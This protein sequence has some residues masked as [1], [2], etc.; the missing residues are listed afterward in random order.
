M[1]ATHRGRKRT[2]EIS[3][4]RSV[5]VCVCGARVVGQHAPHVDAAG[6]HAM[7]NVVHVL[8]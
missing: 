2:G 6:V 1:S 4:V 8:V 3:G 7:K 5:C